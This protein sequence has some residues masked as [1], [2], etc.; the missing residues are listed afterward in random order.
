V[1][2]TAV[3]LVALR[4]AQDLEGTPPEETIKAV[5]ETYGLGLEELREQVIR[6]RVFD[7]LIGNLGRTDVDKLFVPAEGRVALVDQ[8]EAFGLSIDLDPALLIPCRP[9]PADLR[10]YLMML[11]AEEL[12]ST[13][14]DYL[15]DA[16]IEALLQRR[17][18]VLELCS[19]SAS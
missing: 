19:A 18:R 16:Q 8:D 10:V 6:A 4:S 11:N 1:S 15:N 2:E 7:G 3:D 17:D 14:G 12:Q 9:I 5:A 13:L